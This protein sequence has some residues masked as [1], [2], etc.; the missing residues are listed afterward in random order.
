L[1]KEPSIS[2]IIPVY[3]ESEIINDLISHI[4]GIPSGKEIEIIV[5]DGASERDTLKAIKKGHVKKISSEK[6]RG[7]QMNTGAQR[8]KG[9]ILLFLH[10][11][12]YLPENAFD[13]VMKALSD[14]RISGGAFTLRTD[15][16]NPVFNGL[17]FLYD[18]RSIITRIPYGDQ[19]IFIRRSVFEEMGGYKEYQL[20]E[21]VDLMER[22]RKEGY[23]IK[24]LGNKVITSGRRYREKGPIRNLIRNLILIFLYKI[25]IH[26]DRLAK[27][28]W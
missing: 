6:G 21:E 1:I 17:M 19:A 18:L 14:R 9:G 5:V 7:A 15:W 27:W 26:P 2:I 16:I 10:A 22:M 8:S 25:G 3:N 13:K 28:Y 24:I 11:D 4:R 12:T 23:K 20:F